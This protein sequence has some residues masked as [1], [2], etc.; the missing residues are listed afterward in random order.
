M[1]KSFFHGDVP[2]GTVCGKGDDAMYITLDQLLAI[3]EYSMGL[4][5]LVVGIVAILSKKK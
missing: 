2:S 3:L 4:I 1:N 5:T